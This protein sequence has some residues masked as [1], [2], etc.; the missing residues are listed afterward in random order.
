MK[1]A[2][3]KSVLDTK[4][5]V[6]IT[7]YVSENMEEA[8]VDSFI[9]QYK[10]G[11]TCFLTNTNEEALKILGVLNK[12]GKRA[13]LIQS[14]DGFRLSNLLEV[15]FFLNIIDKNLQSP[16][17]SNELWDSAKRA[18]YYKFKNSS[19]YGNIKNMI[20][21][22]EKIYS[23]KYR[24]DLE[25]FV[26]ESNY[27]DFYDDSDK[28]VI[29]VST[30]HKS[31]GREFDNVYMMLKNEQLPNDEARRKIY[32]GM[33]R[34]KNELYIHTNTNIFD[35]YKNDKIEFVKD[36]NYYKEPLEIMLQTTHKDV[37]LDYF[38]GKKEIISSLRSGMPL[39]IDDIFL[40]A[41][42][43][44]RDVRIAKFSKSF[45]EKLEMLKNNGYKLTKASIQF[46]VY[47]KN[48]QDEEDTPI[49]LS[50]LFFVK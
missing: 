50:N 4:G 46:I 11:K 42:L 14:I 3:C 23:I 31:K 1:G 15:R 48:E 36:K 40:S 26:R 25:E 2:Q 18:L 47:W 27:E 38:K 20:M 17:I 5:I 32:V 28:E 13:R 39:K 8:I 22:F 21:D 12:K 19:C 35:D 10:G 33:T 24:T 6:K 30:I 34:A 43:N 16:V 7:R 44:G 45:I 29:Y 37:V 41:T 49:I 9:S